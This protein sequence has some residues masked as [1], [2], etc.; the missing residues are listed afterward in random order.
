MRV[1][2]SMAGL[3][4][5]MGKSQVG[6]WMLGAFLPSLLL[7]WCMLAILGTA[8]PGTV[9]A[10][11]V[12][13]RWAYIFFWLA[14][15]GSA[16]ATVCGPRLAPLARRRRELGLAFAAA[17]VPHAALVAWLFYILP[18]PPMSRARIVY[19]GVALVL[20]YLL[21]LL[22]IRCVSAKLTPALSRRIRFLGV[23]YIAL[24][25]LR[26]FLRLPLHSSLPERLSYVPF[27]ALAVV[28]TLLRLAHL[29]ANRSWKFNDLPRGTRSIRHEGMT[30]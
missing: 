24:A 17:M 22:S 1:E 9:F 21:A 15:T 27:I 10:L 18:T 2:S 28:A 14:Y 12:T 26:D 25:F 7:A 4:E 16:L 29:F 6:W 3:M 5:P 8:A 23:E 13:A 20:T 19:F 30:K 11:Q